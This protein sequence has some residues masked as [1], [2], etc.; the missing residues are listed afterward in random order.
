M[1]ASPVL[2]A[3]DN[4]ELL[5][6]NDA[7]QS[8][9]VEVVGRELRGAAA[10]TLPASAPGLDCT[11]L[12]RARGDPMAREKRSLALRSSHCVPR[13]A[14]VFRSS[15]SALVAVLGAYGSK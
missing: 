13:T 3:V 1:E 5:R 14:F 12:R 15:C 11:H 9:P 10:D 6:V 4:I 2:A 8:H 7:I